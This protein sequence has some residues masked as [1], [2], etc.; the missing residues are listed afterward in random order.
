VIL[1][2]WPV[3]A[4]GF[5]DALA[6]APIDVEARAPAATRN[7]EL[8]DEPDKPDKPLGATLPTTCNTYNRPS[9]LTGR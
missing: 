3:V 1:S 6:L 9:E 2:D 5:G 7:A 8:P 4:I